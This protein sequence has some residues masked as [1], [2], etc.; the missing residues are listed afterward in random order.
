MNLR[1]IIYPLAILLCSAGILHAQGNGTRRI[2]P[3]TG[4][5]LEIPDGFVLGGL[6]PVF[7][8]AANE[9]SLAVREVPLSFSELLSHYDTTE[10]VMA[11]MGVTLLSYEEPEI[12]G[13]RAKLYHVRRAP[14]EAEDASTVLTWLLLFGD[15]TRSVEAFG[16]YTDASPIEMA[17]VLRT[18]LLGIRW[19]RARVVPIG[20]DVAYT[21]EPRGNFKL[22]ASQLQSLIFTENGVDPAASATDAEIY[23]VAQPAV[24]LDE[25]TQLEY[26]RGQITA[27]GRLLKAKVI[28][29][30]RLTLDGL[31]AVELVARG[32]D[33]DTR[34]PAMAYHMSIYDASTGELYEVMATIPPKRSSKLLPSIKQMAR[35]FKRRSGPR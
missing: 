3:G 35:T 7:I 34:A 32:E 28:E 9:A 30:K 11:S 27:E 19:D 25:G 17:E 4:V 16:G 26:T 20:E 18:S 31:P 24:R 23:A 13:Y 1:R 33:P 15:S 22:K 5:S 21:I 10:S 2:F 29:T 14:G 8:Q 12:D 6:D